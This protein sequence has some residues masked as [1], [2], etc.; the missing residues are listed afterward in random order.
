M[1]LSG[2]LDDQKRHALQYIFAYSAVWGLGGNLDS[3][4]REKFDVFMRE[5]FEGS[6][7]FPGGRSGSVF[8]YRLD[9]GRGFSFAPWEELVPAFKYNPAQ[10]YFNILVHT[11]DSIR[12]AMLLESCLAVGRPVLFSGGSGVGKSAVIVDTLE[13]LAATTGA[14]AAAGNKGGQGY[15]PVVSPFISPRHLR[16][17]VP[18]LPL[19]PPPYPVSFRCSISVPRPAVTP[20]RR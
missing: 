19:S 10:P 14:A 16:N 20:P 8:D 4:S 17:S 5:L 12:M 7:N 6:V 1:D 11:V 3:A 13:R 9:S 2:A 18:D 15:V